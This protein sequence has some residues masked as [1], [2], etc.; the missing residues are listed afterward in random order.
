MRPIRI[1]RRIAKIAVACVFFWAVKNF[2]CHHFGK[3][4][5]SLPTVAISLGAFLWVVERP[6]L[7]RWFGFVFL[8][9]VLQARFSPRVPVA[10]H[11]EC[12]VFSGALFSV[13][14]E[15]SAKG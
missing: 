1:R 11:F 2:S 15:I 10:G 4:A 3:P 6:F 14:K 8:G 7:A 13:P 9:F 12:S 5:D